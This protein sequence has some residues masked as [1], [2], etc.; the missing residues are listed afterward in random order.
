MRTIRLRSTLC[1]QPMLDRSLYAAFHA[2]RRFADITSSKSSRERCTTVMRHCDTDTAEHK[3]AMQSSLPSPTAGWEDW[4]PDVLIVLQPP[5]SSSGWSSPAAFGGCASR[6]L[7]APRVAA[8]KEATSAAQS[9][10]GIGDGGCRAAPR[11]PDTG[12]KPADGPRQAAA[13]WRPPDP[14]YQEHRTPLRSRIC[15]DLY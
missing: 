7:E 8:G 1:S 14:L 2:R 11:A 6:P 3:S 9:G 13:V 15:S 5:G 4:L 12:G 10:D